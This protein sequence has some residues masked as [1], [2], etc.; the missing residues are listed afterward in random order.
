MTERTQMTERAVYFAKITREPRLFDRT[1]HDDIFEALNPRHTV[2]RYNRTWRFSR[3]HDRGVFIDGKLGFVRRTHAE[4]VEYDEDRQ[5]FVTTEAIASQGSV[6]FFAID[7]E[8]EILAFEERPPAIRRQSFLGNFRA[9]LSEADFRSTVVLLRDPSEYAGF[10]ATVDR[11]SRVR[12]VVFAP[13]PGW[14]EDAENLRQ[15]V[16]QARAKRAEVVAT[17]APGESLDPHAEW[18]DGALGQIAEH[19]EGNLKATGYRNGQKRTWTFGA[20]L[21]IALISETETTTPDGIWG[22]MRQKIEE[23][24]GRK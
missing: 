4:G 22:W 7:T 14:R 5:D 12:A 24:Y 1:F 21:Q 6:S 13:N 10:V 16:E 18:I 17:A 19:G 2:T 3:P 20:R 11:V 15:I 9:L 8:R 23:I